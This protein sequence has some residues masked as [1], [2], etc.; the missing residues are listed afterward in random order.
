MNMLNDK[1]SIEEFAA[2]LDGNLSEED[3]M[4]VSAVI[5][6]DEHLVQILDSTIESDDSLNAIMPTEEVVI[7]DILNDS[8]F[9]LPEI[10]INTDDEVV[11]L[12]AAEHDD[13][14]LRAVSDDVKIAAFDD[15]MNTDAVDDAGISLPEDG[16]ETWHQMPEANEVLYAENLDNEDNNMEIE[17]I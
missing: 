1:V 7:P 15:E 3:M 13:V 16:G 11:L 2:F 14:E 5:D 12:A 10:T 4:A 9:E 17:I 6:S 8:D